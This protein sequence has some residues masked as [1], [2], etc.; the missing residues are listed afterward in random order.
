MAE[1]VTTLDAATGEVEVRAYTPEELAQAQA[2]QDAATA[3]AEAREAALAKLQKLGL[4]LEDLTALG[5]V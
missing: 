1:D 2:D 4:S 3:E 5:L